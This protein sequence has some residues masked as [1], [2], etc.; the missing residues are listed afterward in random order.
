MDD[1]ENLLLDLFQK[2]S[3]KTITLETQPYNDLGLFGGDLL[4][5]WEILENKYNVDLFGFDYNLYFPKEG[6]ASLKDVLDLMRGEFY[7]KKKKLT[8]QHLSRVAKLGKWFEP[9]E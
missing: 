1:T 6:V 2:Y 5:V 8:I 4:E 3:S 9:E 7:G